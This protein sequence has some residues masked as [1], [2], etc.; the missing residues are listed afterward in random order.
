VREAQSD[1]PKTSELLSITA[2]CLLL[3][4]VLGAVESGPIRGVDYS[5]PLPFLSPRPPGQEVTISTIHQTTFRTTQQKVAETTYSGSAAQSQGQGAPSQGFVPP[6]GI[7]LLILYVL[8]PVICAVGIG[9][10]LLL[11]RKEEPEVF[12]FRSAL[13]EMQK[14]RSYFLSTWSNKLRNAA[15]LRYYLMMTKICEKAGMKSMPEETPNEF[16][17]RVSTSLATGEADK[18]A[19]FAETVDKAHYS[20]EFSPTEVAEAAR[21]METFIQ[22]IMRVV[23]HGTKEFSG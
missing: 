8:V 16:I 7:D 17:S 22:G 11:A 2:V 5:F 10:A 19:R 12:D 15:L 20:V 18:S 14:E 3:I 23:E 6:Q 13:D 21:Y 4:V 1:V 9:L